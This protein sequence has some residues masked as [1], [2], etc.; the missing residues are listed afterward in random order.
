MGRGVEKEVEMG[1]WGWRGENRLDRNTWGE[2]KGV[3]E[4][5]ERE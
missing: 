3:R 1:E 5:R 4:G 2:E